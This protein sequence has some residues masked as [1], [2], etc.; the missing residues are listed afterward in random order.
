M[1]PTFRQIFDMITTIIVFLFANDILL[2]VD[3]LVI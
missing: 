3:P 2:A 1:D